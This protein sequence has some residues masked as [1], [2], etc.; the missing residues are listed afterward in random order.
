MRAFEIIEG[1]TPIEREVSPF[2]TESDMENRVHQIPSVLLD[3]QI[4]IIGRQ[5]G[6][7]TGTL[8]L[9]GLDKYGNSVVFELKKGDSG[10]GS[11]SEGSIL[12][13]PQQYAQALQWLSYDDLAETYGDYRLMTKSKGWPT[14]P[15]PEEDSLDEAFASHFGTGLQKEKFNQFQRMVIVAEEITDLTAAHARY[16]RDE[17]LNLQ[18]VEIQRFR[19]SD[20][21][22][23]SPTIIAST[24]VDY[25]EK[26]VQPSGDNKLTFPEVNKEIVTR[27]FPEIKDI[28]VASSPDELFPKGFDHR[29]PR[30]RSLN[31]NHPDAV[32]Y[33]LRVRPLEEGHVK[34]SIDVTDRGLASDCGNKEA[35][36]R[37][38]HSA[39]NRFIDAGFDVHDRSRWRVVTEH[40]D[41]DRVT[42]IRS[43]SFIEEV[44]NRYADLVRVGHEVMQ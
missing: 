35:L 1:D 43:G 25:D 7:E 5:V 10:S 4:L 18:C 3:E 19:L 33:A 2:Q 8:D 44:A 21:N 24:V 42:E 15:L 17:G 22:R 32:R 36:T 28:T 39:K 26:R 12:S 34:I 16:L 11:A 23:T 20:R 9:L 29:E 14:T 30:M 41:I 38:I 27:V 40:W 13:Q 31:S 37:R 6:V